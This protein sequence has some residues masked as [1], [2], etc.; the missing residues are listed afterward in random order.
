MLSGV[1]LNVLIL[2]V[3]NDF[4]SL[5]QL[6]I[7]RMFEY[8]PKLDLQVAKSNRTNLKHTKQ[9]LHQQHYIIELAIIVFQFVIIS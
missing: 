4:N 7:Q 8:S 2:I 5:I 6:I 3:L 9:N 1:I